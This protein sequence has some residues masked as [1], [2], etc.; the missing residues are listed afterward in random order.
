MPDEIVAL[1]AAFDA[2]DTLD[3]DAQQR[4]L[5]WLTDRFGTDEENRVAQLE[6]TPA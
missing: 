4:C 1:Q 5:A 3:Y 2:L 6:T